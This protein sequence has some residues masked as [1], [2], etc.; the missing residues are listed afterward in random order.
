[1][2]P[3]FFRFFSI[4]FFRSSERTFKI[5]RMTSSFLNFAAL[6]RRNCFLLAF[7]LF[8]LS[9]GCDGKISPSQDELQIRKEFHIPSDA[10]LVSFWRSSDQPGTF[11]R[12]GLR[13]V[14]E[15]QFTDQ[16]KEAFAVK[17]PDVG[18]KP[19]P[20]P[21]K[22]NR[23]P[24]PPPVEIFQ[25]AHEGAF[26]CSVAVFGKWVKGKKQEDQ[27]LS[28]EEAPETFDHYRLAVFDR[29]TG[30]IKIVSQNYY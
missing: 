30:R 17:S 25:N 4:G 11:G 19:L 28:C 21:E 2:C 9:G 20:V 29:A 14:A 24:H 3:G 23:F 15:F 8:L 1:M 13:L 27:I 12:E 5:M 26:F 7:V 22:V 10:A 18:W 16:Q 6:F